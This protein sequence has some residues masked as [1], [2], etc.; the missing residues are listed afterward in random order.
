V[1]IKCAPAL[2]PLV[3][4]AAT[5]AFAGNGMGCAPPG[6]SGSN[7]WLWLLAVVLLVAGLCAILAYRHFRRK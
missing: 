7:L 6:C 4:L 3:L 2:L 5:P 1:T